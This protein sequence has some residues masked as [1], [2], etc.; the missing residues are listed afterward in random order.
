MVSTDAGADKYE[1]NFGPDPFLRSN[2]R[3]W[4]I[5]VF[6][7]LECIFIGIDTDY[8]QYTRNDSWRNQVGFWDLFY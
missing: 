8:L 3:L 5:M 4:G 7:V 1:T 6:L 2:R